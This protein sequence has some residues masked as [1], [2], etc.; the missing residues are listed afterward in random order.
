ML[1]QTPAL[2]HKSPFNS[3]QSPQSR[4]FVDFQ[5][6][7]QLVSFSSLDFNPIVASVGAGVWIFDNIGIDVFYD[8]GI[9]D[10]Y[11]ENF[12]VEIEEAAGFG[13]RFQTPPKRG[14]SGYVNVGFV[15]YQVL[16]TVNDS[17]G[18][19]R[20]SEG[21]SGGRIAIGLSQQLRHFDFLSVTGE[22]RNY[23]SDEDLQADSVVV[24]LR[25]NFK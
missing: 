21:F 23:F 12:L 13:L 7:T 16:L 3:T 2:A 19:R 9:S 8:T 20:V 10:D 18:T 11:S 17:L 5:W 14:F 15:D 25:L 4:I 1:M 24:G 6:G 22:Y